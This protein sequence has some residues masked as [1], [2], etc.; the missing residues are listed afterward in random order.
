MQVTV[1]DLQC[2]IGLK[3]KYIYIGLYGL[4]SKYIDMNTFP[5]IHSHGLKMVSLFES[6]CVLLWATFFKDEEC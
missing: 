3:E 6:T 4:Y 5:T 1:I 2:N